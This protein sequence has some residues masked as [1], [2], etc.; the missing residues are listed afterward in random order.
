MSSELTI[1]ALYGLVVA[2]TI[3]WQVL[4]AMAQ[5][6]LPML[7]TARDDMPPLTGTAGRLKRAVTNSVTA[8]ALFAPAVLI[9]AQ[10]DRLGGSGLLAAQAFLVARILYVPVYAFG[11]PWLRTVVWAVGFLATLVLTLL[12]L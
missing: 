9:L 11:I 8:M 2:L 5:V 7:A 6:G 1:L 3:V 4:A 12:A 10:T